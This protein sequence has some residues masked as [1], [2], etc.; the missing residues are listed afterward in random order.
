V[1]LCDLCARLFSWTSRAVFGINY[2]AFAVM[3]A[4][5]CV[6]AGYWPRGHGGLP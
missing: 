6:T 5:A 1:N 3:L 4:D 2:R